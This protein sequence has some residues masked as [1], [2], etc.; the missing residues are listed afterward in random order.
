MTIDDSPKH[1]AEYAIHGLPCLVPEKSYN[2]KIWNTHNV[3][4][5]RDF[6][7]SLQLIKSL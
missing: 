1:A 2:R 6:D 4:V 5:Y 3:F 7:Y